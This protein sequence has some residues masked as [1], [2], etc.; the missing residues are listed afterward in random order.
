MTDHQGEGS[1]SNAHAGRQFEE[2]VR[3]LLVKRLPD[4]QQSFSVEVG[5]LVKK[6]HRF[7]FG[8]SQHKAIIGCKSHT[9]TKTDK[10]PSA[11]MTTWD[12][13]ML[14]FYLALRGWRKLFVVRKDLRHCNSES[15]Y[16]CTKD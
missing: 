10:V 13:A 8:S 16:V 9:W 4:S 2:A 6:R 5:H 11:K 14:Y 3:R 12:Q 7:D 1:E 15:L